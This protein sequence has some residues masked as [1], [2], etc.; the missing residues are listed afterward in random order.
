MPKPD[1]VIHLN[2]VDTFPSS[3]KEL[4]IGLCNAEVHDPRIALIWDE[5]SCGFLGRK[6]LQDI[7]NICWTCIEKLP[8][9]QP[10]NPYYLFGFCPKT[11]KLFGS[12]RVEK[13][14]S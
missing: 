11:S 7:K 13:E 1:K 3:L 2:V 6:K 12:E 5:I 9:S 8:E 4:E 14:E 10:G